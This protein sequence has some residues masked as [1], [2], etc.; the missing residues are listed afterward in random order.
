MKGLKRFEFGRE[1][2]CRH[3]GAA[4]QGHDLVLPNR[5]KLVGDRIEPIER[6]VHRVEISLTATGQRQASIVPD[7]QGRV[8]VC[9]ELTNLLTYSCLGD[10]QILRR[11]RKIQAPARC[12]ESSQDI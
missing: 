7:E 6:F 2:E 11:L 1:P 9:L 8:Q 12:F 10:F 4:V 3:A 5:E